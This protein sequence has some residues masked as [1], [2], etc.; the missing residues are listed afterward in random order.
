[1]NEDERV[2]VSSY[3]LGQGRERNWR[4]LWPRVVGARL[5]L[6]DAFVDVS[7]TQGNFRASPEDW[8]IREV[9]YHVLTGSQSVAATIERLV[10]GDDAGEVQWAD[11]VRQQP[12]VSLA[13]LHQQ[14]LADSVIFSSM[15]GRFSDDVSLE[16]TS[17]HM[18]FGPLHCRAWFLFQRIHDR[19]HANQV[20]AVKAARGYPD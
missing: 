4:E 19:D 2:R 8:T 11:P 15:A 14:L 12:V 10:A 13:D 7:E 1:M 17:P 20:Q 18:S 3:L 6:L 16:P 9:A 5:E